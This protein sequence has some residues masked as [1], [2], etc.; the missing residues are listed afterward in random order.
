MMKMP[1]SVILHI[2]AYLEES[3]HTL[4]NVRMTNKKMESIPASAL[5]SAHHL[6]P[7]LSQHS[8][9]PSCSRLQPCQ[10]HR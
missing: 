7:H 1:N 4:W 9:S 6:R 2:P 5:L 3:T 10:H 8:S